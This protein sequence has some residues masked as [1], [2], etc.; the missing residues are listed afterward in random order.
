LLFTDLKCVT[1]GE[2][3]SC[4][5]LVDIY[6]DYIPTLTEVDDEYRKLYPNEYDEVGFV[7]W[8]MHQYTEKRPPHIRSKLNGKA[9]FK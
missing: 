7:N 9:V 5:D 2:T 4:D 6:W 1:Y 8:K 3:N